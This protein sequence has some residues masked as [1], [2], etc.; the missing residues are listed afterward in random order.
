MRSKVDPY[1]LS[2][3]F[4][5]EYVD[6]TRSWENNQTEDARVYLNNYRCLS[7]LERHRPPTAETTENTESDRV[8][9]QNAADAW[10]VSVQEITDVY[11]KLR[12]YFLDYGEMPSGFR[13]LLIDPTWFAKELER[14]RTEQE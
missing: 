7:A 14:W 12:A 11:I 4:I 8:M 2:D 1:C 10:E 3:D 5:D 9:L 13:D 6:Q